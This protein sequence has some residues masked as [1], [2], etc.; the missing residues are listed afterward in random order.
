MHPR[1]LIVATAYD[2]YI[3]ILNIDVCTVF[4]LLEVKVSLIFLARWVFRPLWTDVTMRGFPFE[5]F[6]SDC[7]LTFMFCTHSSSGFF[8]RPFSATSEERKNRGLVNRTVDCYDS[9]LASLVIARS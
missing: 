5:N 7:S 2:L 4:E 6:V 1:C 8:S 9:S 3:I